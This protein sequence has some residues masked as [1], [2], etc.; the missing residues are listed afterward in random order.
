MSFSPSLSLFIFLSVRPPLPPML[1]LSR[2]CFCFCFPRN[3]TTNCWNVYFITN[4][5]EA[6]AKVRARPLPAPSQGFFPQP[7]ERPLTETAEFVLSSQ[8]RHERAAQEFRD[9]VRMEEERARR[10]TQVR[11][12]WGERGGVEHRPY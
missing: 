7:S 2:R 1:Y 4:Q 5:E 8:T 9:R 11:G 12:S 10:A 3:G 6:A